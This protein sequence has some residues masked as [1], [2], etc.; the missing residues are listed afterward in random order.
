MFFKADTATRKNHLGCKPNEDRS[1]LNPAAGLACVADEVSRISHRAGTY[2]VLSLGE[3]AS[4]QLIENC[5]SLAEK[6]VLSRSKI[7]VDDLFGAFRTTSEVL[8][9]FVLHNGP[10]D[11]Y[12][13]DYPGTIGTIITTAGQELR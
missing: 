12:E 11:L 1:Y 7:S 8:K 2:P 4:V 9:E 6:A 13:Y 3:F 5:K 10:F